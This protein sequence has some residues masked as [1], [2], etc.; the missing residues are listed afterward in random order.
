[1]VLYGKPGIGIQYT[2]YIFPDGHA[3]CIEAVEKMAAE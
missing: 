1:M 2:G 3:L